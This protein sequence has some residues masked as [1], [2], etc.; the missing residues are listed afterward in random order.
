MVDPSVFGLTDLVVCVS[1]R[2]VLSETLCVHCSYYYYL[3]YTS[4]R[5]VC[6]IQLGQWD[7]PMHTSVGLGS[8]TITKTY[9][10]ST[11]L[12][13]TDDGVGALCMKCSTIY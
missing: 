4:K 11:I 3:L 7:S 9:F 5:R 12:Y 1:K 6:S 2:T 8:S 10:Y 13:L